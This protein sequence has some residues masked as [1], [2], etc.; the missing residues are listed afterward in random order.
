MLVSRVVWMLDGVC[1]LWIEVWMSCCD[2]G[3]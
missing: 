3:Y 2:C 1:E